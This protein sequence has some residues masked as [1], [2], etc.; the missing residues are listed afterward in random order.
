MCKEAVNACLSSLE[1]VPDWF[2]TKKMLKNL[3][4]TESFNED[5]LC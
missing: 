3:D 1:F 2:V 4:K 5:S